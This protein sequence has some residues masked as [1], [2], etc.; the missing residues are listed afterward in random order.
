MGVCGPLCTYD[1]LDQRGILSNKPRKWSLFGLICSLW[2]NADAKWSLFKNHLL[3]FLLNEMSSNKTSDRIE[4]CRVSIFPHPIFWPAW[5]C[6]CLVS[7]ASLVPFHLLATTSNWPTV[8][9]AH[10]L[11]FQVEATWLWESELR[12]GRPQEGPAP[13]VSSPFLTWA[14]F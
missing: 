2:T 13:L 12:W 6:P 4:A 5:N 8:C 9:P 7:D 1:L 3:V 11:S 10:S 14:F